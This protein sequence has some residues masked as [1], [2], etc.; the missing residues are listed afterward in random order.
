[1]QYLEVI[2]AM[3]KIGQVGCIHMHNC[4]R[5]NSTRSIMAG[6]NMDQFGVCVLAFL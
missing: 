4:I 2:Y 3:D 6:L 5:L 1:M